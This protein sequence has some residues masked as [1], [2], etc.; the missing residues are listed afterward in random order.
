MTDDEEQIPI[1]VGGVQYVNKHSIGWVLSKTGKPV[2]EKMSFILDKALEDYRK[3]YPE[4]Q[5]KEDEGTYRASRPSSPASRSRPKKS[6]EPINE[7]ES[8][9]PIK[10]GSNTYYYR[11]GTGWVDKKTKKKVPDELNDF[12]DN[13][14]AR[15]DNGSQEEGQES[16][17]GFLSRFARGSGRV[18]KQG[19]K[20]LAGNTALNFASRISEEIPIARHFLNPALGIG[21]NFGGGGYYNGIGSIFSPNSG[22]GRGGGGS[23]KDYTDVL[24]KILLAVI[25]LNQSLGGKS[26]GI[27]GSQISSSGLSTA[28]SS[29]GILSAAGGMFGKS[30]LGRLAS[31]V[32]SGVGNFAKKV[33][34]NAVSGEGENRVSSIFDAPTVNSVVVDFDSNALRKLASIMGGNSGGGLGGGIFGPLG[35]M[36]TGFLEGL[37]G[38]LGLKTLKSAVGSF[39]KGAPEALAEGVTRDAGGLLRNSKGQFVSEEAGVVKAV[40]PNLLSRVGT[41]AK[42]LVEKAPGGKVVTAGLKGGAKGLGKIARFAKGLTKIPLLGPLLV[43]GF[44]INDL[45]NIQGEVDA[46]IISEEEGH[47]KS[48]GIA[49]QA[50][51][52]ILGGEGGAAIGATLGSVVPG[53]GTVIGGLVGGIGGYFAGGAIGEYAADKIYDHFANGKEEAG[54]NPQQSSNQSNPQFSSS[55]STPKIMGNPS[56]IPAV[57]NSQSRQNSAMRD[58]MLFGG[59]SGGSQSVVNAPSTTINNMNSSNV[60]NGST[61]GDRGSLDLG[62]VL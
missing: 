27:M 54:S 50:I 11:N 24:T 20:N 13:E 9:D 58:N 42:G 41:A 59:N 22:N 16:K 21:R 12:I 19:A 43:G 25:S 38:L 10:I 15:R 44:A 48:V 8:P 40:K 39:F 2:S 30:G 14:V 5:P 4:L 7:E 29:G 47:K 62:S 46:G 52:A 23:R 31:G 55:P 33:F 53:L 28:P 6:T 1:S 49:G 34:G 60:T 61:V 17:P 37:G 3:Q 56:K 57:F 36:L 35:K 45:Y 32:A 26:S 51:G 18:L